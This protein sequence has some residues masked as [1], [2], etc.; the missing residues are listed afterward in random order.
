MR[1]RLIIA[2]FF[3]TS[4]MSANSEVYD[5][6][7]NQRLAKPV[8]ANLEAQAERLRQENIRLENELLRQELQRKQRESQRLEE[9]RARL[10]REELER[11]RARTESLEPQSNEVGPSPELDVYQQLRMIGQLRDD[12]ILTAEEFQKLKAKILESQ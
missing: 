7:A 4:W 12:G 2:L 8:T 3:L 10:K 1:T 9:E 6:A 11:E 5:V